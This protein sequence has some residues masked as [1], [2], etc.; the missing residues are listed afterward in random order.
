MAVPQTIYRLE[1]VHP[2][3]P[4][5]RTGGFILVAKHPE[6]ACY[7]HFPLIILW[8]SPDRDHEV[9]EELL[10]PETVRN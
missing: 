1:L 10:Y 8:I 4:R 9:P 7:R 2:R 5:I 6:I 3:Q